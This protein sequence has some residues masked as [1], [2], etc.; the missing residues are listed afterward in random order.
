MPLLTFLSVTFAMTWIA[1]FV[2]GAIS[3]GEAARGASALVFYLGVFAPGIVALLMTWRMEGRT[4]V[5]ALLGRLFQWKVGLRWYAF[6]LGYMGVVK[7]TAAV[8]HRLI[9]GEWPRFGEQPVL[10]M[11]AATVFS[12]VILGQAGEEL[13]WR[14]YA[15][16]RLAARFGMGTA[17]VLLGVIW[18]VWHLPLFILE[19][20]GTTDQSFPVYLLQVTALS[21]AIAWVYHNTGGS[22][23]L[24]ML[25]HAAIN[26]TKDIVPSASATPPG[27]WSLSS[28]VVSWLTVG[29]LWMGAAYFLVRIARS[30]S[31]RSLAP[32]P[33]L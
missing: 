18:A 8:L 9:A 16:P 3:P 31:S 27:V 2:A 10:L 7:L 33:F 4:A 28:S 23:L 21:V 12:T 24:T 6:A 17:S 1:W 13:G 30:Q 14:G 19:G 32:S 15:L 11:L 26:N 5:G 20:T 25:L 29:L 22:L